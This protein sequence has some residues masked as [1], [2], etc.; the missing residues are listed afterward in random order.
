MFDVEKLKAPTLEAARFARE[1]LWS[2]VVPDLWQGGT[3]DDDVVW[4]GERQAQ[5]SITLKD[6][7]FVTTMYADANPVHWF[8]QEIRYGI[9]D[10]NMKDFDIEE[11]MEVVNMT[12]RAWK[13]GKRVLIRCQAGWNR[14]GLVTALVLIKDG[15]EAKDA[16][17]LLR[18][19]RSPYALCNSTFE[20]WLLENGAEVVK[21]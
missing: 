9:Y 8:V 20:A 15:M 2:E 18:E 5:H 1:E 17:A 21:N 7:D 3:H 12:H 6:F 14:S 13:K 4:L 10:S 16:I 19:K 11:L